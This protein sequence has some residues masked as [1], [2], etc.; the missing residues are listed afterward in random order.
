MS[1][2]TTR[3]IREVCFL[4]CELWGMHNSSLTMKFYSLFV[5]FFHHVLLLFWGYCR[6]SHEFLC[7]MFWWREM[8]QCFVKKIRKLNTSSCQ[9]VQTSIGSLWLL[10]YK[11]KYFFI[12]IQWRFQQMLDTVLRNL[13]MQWLEY[14]RNIFLEGSG[15]L[16]S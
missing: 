10:T 7:Q 4:R 13:Q 12:W 9:Y 15:P 6:S 2:W 14:W 5:F 3:A 16:P 11:R 8:Y 1:N